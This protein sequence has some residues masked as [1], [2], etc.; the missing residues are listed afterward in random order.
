M[1]PLQWFVLHTFKKCIDKC[2]AFSD[3]SK[4]IY[5]NSDTLKNIQMNSFLWKAMST[6]GFQE[7]SSV[8]LCQLED[9][10]QQSNQQNK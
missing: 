10:F 4:S 1:S 3:N 7:E 6:A 2:K 5:I 9:H 8:H